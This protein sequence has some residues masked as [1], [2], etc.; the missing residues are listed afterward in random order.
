M[1]V[2]VNKWILGINW[3]QELENHQNFPWHLS[4]FLCWFDSYPSLTTS[5]LWFPMYMRGNVNLKIF[6]NSSHWRLISF[7]API[8]K[9]KEGI[10]IRKEVLLNPC[11]DGVKLGWE[12][13][14]S[15][16][17]TC[18][19]IRGKRNSWNFSAINNSHHHHHRPTQAPSKKHMHFIWS[20]I[21][22]RKRS[23]LKGHLSGSAR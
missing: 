4:A 1:P 20:C 12:Q 22:S 5:F 3:N 19:R 7:L 17:T 8:P 9:S 18:M 16:H 15:H 2:C 6:Y 21:S 23:F 13:A 11:M 10:L 14:G